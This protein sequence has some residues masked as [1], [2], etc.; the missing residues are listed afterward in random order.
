M[1][2]RAQWTRPRGELV[3]CPFTTVSN[4]PNPEEVQEVVDQLKSFGK[5][6]LPFQMTVDQA[7]E[8]LDAVCAL[9]SIDDGWDWDLDA[10]KDAVRHLASSHPD[11]DKRDHVFGIYTLKN[12]IR[13]W[14]PPGQSDPQRAP[15]SATTET[16]IRAAAGSSPSLGFYHNV[17]NA[18]AGW[19]GSPL[20]WPDLFVPDGAVP[21]VFANNRRNAPRRRKRK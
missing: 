20:V 14:N 12:T 18:T 8:L 4:D 1:A 11:E 7:C 19:S 16:A 10:L 17:G 13:K 2:T 6:A 3:P 21:T 5:A 15:Y 9:T